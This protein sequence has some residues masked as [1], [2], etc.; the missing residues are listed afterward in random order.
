MY[1]VGASPEFFKIYKDLGEKYGLPVFLNTQLMAMVGLNADHNIVEGDLLV[2]NAHF[3]N[4]EVFEKGKLKDFY[5]SVL[6]NLTSGLNIILI[7]P[8]F[9][10]NEMKG[11]TVHHPNFGSEW[12]QLDFDFFISKA[13]RS[14]LKEYKIELITWKD[15]KRIM[16]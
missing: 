5:E 8:A 4:F 16:M 13:C 3:G 2:K 11:I 9:D 7:H 15:I 12:R 6:R 14:K 10:D 1:S